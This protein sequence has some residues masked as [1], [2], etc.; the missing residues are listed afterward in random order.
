MGIFIRLD[1]MAHGI[2][3]SAWADAYDETLR[4]LRAYPSGLMGWGHR[5]IDGVRVLTF[6]REIE[7]N[8]S[9]PAKRC[10]CILGDFQTLQMAEDHVMFRSLD[11]YRF[12]P[13]E[14]IPDDILA[15]A[16]EP[17]DP[18]RYEETY[19]FV[20]SPVSVLKNKTQDLAYHIPLL[21]AALVIE[22][23]FPRHAL[24]GGNITPRDARKA[25]AWA[26]EVLGIPLASPV[27]MDRA[28]L[29]ARLA[30]FLGEEERG[31]AFEQ[32]YIAGTTNEL[33]EAVF[34]TLTKRHNETLDAL[35]A[36]TSPEH[37]DA[38]QRL[39]LEDVALKFHL[40][41]QEKRD[42]S[43]EA[44][45][46]TTGEAE[47]D[48]RRLAHLLVKR[49]LILTENAWKWIRVEESPSVLEFMTYL[50]TLSSDISMK[51]WNIQRALFENKA[52]CHY[53]VAR[54]SDAPS[55]IFIFA[56]DNEAGSTMKGT[57]SSAGKR[58]AAQP[59]STQEGWKEGWKEGWEEGRQEV[60]HKIARKL[61]A[62]GMAPAEVAKITTLSLE[63][64]RALSH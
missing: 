54:A 36:V 61:L 48:R 23:R 50:A 57:E 32:L 25:K 6:T 63:E 37:L 4:L 18:D 44:P 60:R 14:E 62:Q 15:V 13:S 42:E 9:K 64:V 45:L 52:L 21:A 28:R 46:F 26:E 20:D 34:E 49:S 30:A 10:W 7:R 53:V 2:D 5:K 43:T 24:V 31:D 8:R 29:E 59:G 56:E 19:R 39:A 47:E 55:N 38:K 17:Q 16:Y 12:G 3:P 35:P 11:N 22:T 33:F 51:D 1:I 27:R 41:R 58:G 40:A